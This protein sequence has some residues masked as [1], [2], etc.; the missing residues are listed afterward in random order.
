LRTCFI[1]GN[2][3]QSSI[4]DYQLKTTNIQPFRNTVNRHYMTKIANY[5]E[6]VLKENYR[7]SVSMLEEINPDC[8]PYTISEFCELESESDPDFFRWLFNDPDIN[9][10]GSN[11]TEEEK[12]IATNFF[13]TL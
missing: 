3:Q 13:D 6:K 1:S 5:A 12:E 2:K 4:F 11:L 8:E 10:F 9:D 7:L